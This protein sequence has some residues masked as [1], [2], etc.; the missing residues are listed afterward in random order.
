M[1]AAVAAVVPDII[2]GANLSLFCCSACC[3]H[4]FFRC[5]RPGG[6]Y[7]RVVKATVV[8]CCVVGLLLL[9]SAG[10]RWRMMATAVVAVVPVITIGVNL[11]FSA[12]RFVAVIVYFAAIDPVAATAGSC[13]PLLLLLPLLV[14]VL[15]LSPA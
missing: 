10:V 5:N 4:S 15:L 7:C 1:A 11:S 9:L 8:C 13:Q 14:P 2:I 12:V 3:C 6:H